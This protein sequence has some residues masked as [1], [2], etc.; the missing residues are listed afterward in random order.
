MA[1]R[2]RIAAAGFQAHVDKPFGPNE[3]LEAIKPL[4]PLKRA[5]SSN[6]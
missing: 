4:L 2:N 6:S 3:L 1:D 5:P